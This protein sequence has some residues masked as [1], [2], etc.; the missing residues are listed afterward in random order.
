VEG[1]NGDAEEE[2]GDGETD[3]DRCNGVEELAEPP[4]V[5]SSGNVFNGN[6][7]EVAPGPVF[8]AG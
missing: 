6:V 1:L 7:L 4:E 8:N 2:D 5:E 3:E